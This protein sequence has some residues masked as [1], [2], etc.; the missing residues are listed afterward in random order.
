MLQT[1]DDCPTAQILQDMFT[2]LLIQSILVVGTCLI[3]VNCLYPI[4]PSNSC[5]YYWVIVFN[6]ILNDLPEIFIMSE[7]I[8]QL[9]LTMSTNTLSYNWSQLKAYRTTLVNHRGIKGYKNKKFL[10]DIS[11]E[12]EKGDFYGIVGHWFL[13]NLLS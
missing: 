6:E 10:R 4:L 11:F 2:I 3:M 5:I 8:L 1:I 12:V 7:V 9:K 13:E